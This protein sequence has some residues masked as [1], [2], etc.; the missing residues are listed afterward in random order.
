MGRDFLLRSKLTHLR[1]R[2][3]ALGVM[4]RLL[5]QWNK[6]PGQNFRRRRLRAA[7][8]AFPVAACAATGGQDGVQFDANGRWPVATGPLHHG[9]K[10]GRAGAPCLVVLLERGG[11]TL[12]AATP[13]GDQTCQA[14]TQEQ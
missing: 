14:G 13:C 3:F 2:C 10:K 11:L 6:G 4:L 9:N 12:L 1:R 8:S 7:R 5:E